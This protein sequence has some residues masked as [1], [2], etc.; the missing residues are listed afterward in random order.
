MVVVLRIE[1]SRCAN[2]ALSR[3]YK[4][5]PLS[6]ADD[7]NTFDILWKVFFH[8]SRHFFLCTV[9]IISPQST[10]TVSIWITPA[11]TSNRLARITVTPYV[12]S[13][14]K[15]AVRTGFEPVFFS[16][17]GK[18]GLQTPLTDLIF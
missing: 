17:T 5:R 3:V 18:R 13:I 2:L 6:K 4:A 15:L 16:V 11:A 9:W 10:L 7:L 1:L 12:M 8:K 14:H